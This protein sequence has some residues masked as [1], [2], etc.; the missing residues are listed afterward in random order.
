MRWTLIFIWLL[1]ASTTA[2]A[3]V[4][5]YTLQNGLKVLVTEDH[6]SPLAVFQIW[7]RVGSRDEYSGKTGMSHLL[8]HMMFK[9]TEKYGPGGISRE[10]MRYGGTDNAFTSKEYTAY[11]QILP[12]D[13]IGLSMDIEGVQRAPLQVARDR[14]D[15]GPC[16]NRKEGPFTALQDILQP[17]QRIHRRGGRCQGGQAY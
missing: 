17:R 3:G 14:L 15:V 10:V 6:T 16:F 1:A 12:S 13:R 11:F 5:E 7:Y 8:E 2:F 9:G 4:S